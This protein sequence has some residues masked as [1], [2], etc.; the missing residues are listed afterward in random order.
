MM[1]YLS[2]IIPIINA[3][4]NTS[5]SQLQNAT[6]NAGAEKKSYILIFGQRIVG[7]IDN[8]TKCIFNCR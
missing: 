6:E 3:Q 4:N 1:V 2:M 7:N 5:S 8:S